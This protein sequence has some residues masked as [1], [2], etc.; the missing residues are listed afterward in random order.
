[1]P[2]PDRGQDRGWYTFM[3]GSAAFVIMNTEYEVNHGSEQYT[4]L[5]AAMAAVDRRQTPWLVFAGHRPMYSGNSFYDLRDN[6]PGVEDLE[7]LLFKHRVDVALW[8]HVHNAQ[9]TCPMVNSS[10]REAPCPGC[11]AG[12]VHAIIGNGGQGLSKFPEP[13]A[14]WSLYQ[15]EEWGY[16]EMEIANATHLKL[17]FFGDTAGGLHREAT[18]VRRFPR[19]ESLETEA[20][21]AT[22][23]P[24]RSGLYV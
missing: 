10:C 18:I 5:D 16:N 24:T 15:G 13:R 8:G 7:P 3:R 4:F 2:T 23:Q 19:E 21:R 22:R 17:R 1:M 9:L 20:S 11:Y 6:T 14:A 12:I